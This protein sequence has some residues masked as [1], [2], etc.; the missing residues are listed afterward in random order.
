MVG[1]AVSAVSPAFKGRNVEGGRGGA[2][3]IT[4]ILIAA[5]SRKCFQNFLSP[6]ESP[7][8]LSSGP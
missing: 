5:F 7:E 4:P 1:G 6:K 8:A 3:S 2:R